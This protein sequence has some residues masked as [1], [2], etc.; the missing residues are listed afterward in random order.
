MKKF[1]PIIILTAVFLL[2]CAALVFLPKNNDVILPE[3][4]DTAC[5]YYPHA[6]WGMERKEF[7][8]ATS[9]PSYDFKQEYKRTRLN[10]PEV[11]LTAETEF[12]GEYCRTDFRFIGANCT[13]IKPLQRV[14]IYYKLYDKTYEQLIEEVRELLSVQG[15][16]HTVVFEP[17]TETSPAV[18]RF[19]DNKTTAD[20]NQT[21]KSCY[22][23]YMYD[24]YEHKFIPEEETEVIERCKRK[25]YLDELNAPLTQVCIWYYPEQNT[26][27][28]TFDGTNLTGPTLSLA[29]YYRIVNP[30]LGVRN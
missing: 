22:S 21:V 7:Y 11:V 26:C 17:A 19:I 29:K 1:L 3:E 4:S 10:E 9:R 18:Y 6:E 14:D 24:M 27:V 5:F 15:V 23:L 8:K 12:L 2:I 16:E 20:L 13:N 30:G 25:N 28:I